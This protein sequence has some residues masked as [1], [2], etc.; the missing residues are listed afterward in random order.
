M[1]ASAA[2]GGQMGLEYVSPAR[3]RSVDPRSGRL[4]RHHVS[5]KVP[6]AV[7]A[8]H[9]GVGILVEADEHDLSRAKAGRAEVA[10]GADHG[11]DRCGGR[12]PRRLP[13]VAFLALGDDDSRGGLG[14]GGSI[15]AAELAA[16]GNGLPRL[17]SV[18]V[19]EL[20]RSPTGRSALAVVVPVDSLRHHRPSQTRS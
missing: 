11:I 8:K 5:E 9:L 15:L 20:G 7:L 18:G 17:D 3:R 10:G 4:R 2:R 6:E 1:T 19:Q 13:L 14:Q 12:F 16:G